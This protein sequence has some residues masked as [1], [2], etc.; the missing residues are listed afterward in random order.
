[1]NDLIQS[2]LGGGGGRATGA[3]ASS[4]LESLIGG[5]LGGGQP[6]GRQAP[7]APQG[8]SGAIGDL[9]GGILGGQ[10]GGRAPQGGRDP[11]S[12]LIGG[13]IGGSSRAGGGGGMAD[14]IGSVLG[15]AAGGRSGQAS[16]PIINALAEK[17]GVSPQLAQMV[18]SFFMSRMLA[19]QLDKSGGRVEDMQHGSGSAE[20]EYVDLD[21]LLSF[22]DDD[23]ALQTK[24]ADSGMAHDLAKQSGMGEQE[25]AGALSA[26]VKMLGAQRQIPK[27]VQP[28]NDL[29]DLLDAW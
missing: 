27:P 19:K 16:N 28:N 12:D 4:D 8:G 14:I 1:M 18:V 5:I 21:N 25:A 15:G 6:S 26:L 24:F 9:I 10:S 29:K 13:L 17:I 7:R 20:G 3:P 2:I 23:A 22:Q 11:M